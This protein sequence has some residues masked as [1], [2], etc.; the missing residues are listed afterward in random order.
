M[1]SHGL[2]SFPD[3]KPGGGFDF[4][5]TGI[6]RFSP[7]FDA[8]N[9]ACAALQPGGQ[10][11]PAEIRQH[12]KREMAEAACMRKHGVPYFPDPNS[13]GAIVVQQ[14]SGWD[15]SSPKFRAAQKVCAHLNPGSG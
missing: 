8:A 6:N 15:P 3:P 2:P 13:Q 1:R 4:T 12:V 9:K 5:G 7:Q 14:G 11:T 10:K